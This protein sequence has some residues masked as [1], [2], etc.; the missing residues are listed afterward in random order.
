MMKQ[1]QQN[2]RYGPAL[3]F[4]DIAAAIVEQRRE[5]EARGENRE[6]FGCHLVLRR[7]RKLAKQQTGKKP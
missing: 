6:A 2:Q 3:R 4:S 5:C 7:L 1:Q